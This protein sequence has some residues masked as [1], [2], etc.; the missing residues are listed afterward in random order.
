MTFFEFQKRFPN[1]CAVGYTVKFA[2]MWEAYK[3]AMEE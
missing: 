2:D 1:G 3:K